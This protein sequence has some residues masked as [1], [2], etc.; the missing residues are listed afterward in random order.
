MSNDYVEHTKHRTTKYL[1]AMKA[2]EKKADEIAELCDA[3]VGVICYSTDNL[4]PLFHGRPSLREVVE[5]YMAD[6]LGGNIDSLNQSLDNI[7]LGDLSENELPGLRD[8]LLQKHA[9]LDQAK[10]KLAQNQ[11]EGSQNQGEGSQNQD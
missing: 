9:E 2:L 10:A 3:Q 11:A 6:N 5:K 1:A 4:T 7:N 8:S